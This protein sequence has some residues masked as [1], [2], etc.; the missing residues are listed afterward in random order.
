MKIAETK[1]RKSHVQQKDD[2]R[3]NQMDFKINKLNNQNLK[4][5]KVKGKEKESTEFQRQININHPGGGWG[6]GKMAKNE[7]SFRNLYMNM[8]KMLHLCQ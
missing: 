6:K 2:I 1:Y 3:K 8:Q 4:L 5:V 7:E